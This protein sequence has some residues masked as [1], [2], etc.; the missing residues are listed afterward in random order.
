MWSF[1]KFELRLALQGRVSKGFYE[2]LAKPRRRCVLT[3]AGLTQAIGSQLLAGRSEELAEE[4]HS[5][6]W[7][8]LML[9]LLLGIK[10][11]PGLREFER[12]ARCA[13]D[14]FLRLHPA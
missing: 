5:L 12:R 14:A 6:L 4:F 7:G 13:A 3:R 9:N 10:R 8:D 2:T 11:R 1:N